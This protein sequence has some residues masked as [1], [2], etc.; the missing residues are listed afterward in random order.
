MIRRRAGDQGETG[1]A[2]V[3]LLR[4]IHQPWSEGEQTALIVG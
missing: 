1:L 4:E 2:D 3:T